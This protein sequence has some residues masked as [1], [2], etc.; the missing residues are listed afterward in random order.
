VDYP[1]LLKSKTAAEYRSYYES[2][3]CR[4]PIKTFDGIE[5]RFRKRDFNHC[6]FESVETKDDTF[7][8]ERAER[9]LWI[10]AA[11]Q[12]SSAELYIGWDNRKKKLTDGRR[13]AIV[14]GN[15]VVIIVLTGKLKADFVTAFIAG[16]SS[17]SKIRNSPKWK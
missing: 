9:L 10:K 14:F 5:V 15:Y 12:D 7:S 13:V 16:D 2:N 4:C 8:I 6:F 11:L 1:P 3:Y 17:L